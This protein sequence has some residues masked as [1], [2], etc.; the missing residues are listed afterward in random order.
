MISLAKFSNAQASG[1][2]Q[3]INMDNTKSSV[4]NAAE[5]MVNK[6]SETKDAVSNKASEAATA[7]KHRAE[8]AKT[9]AG[10]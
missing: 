6:A 1:D 9:K 8:E 10:Q 3:I 5:T 7:V 4:K 2:S